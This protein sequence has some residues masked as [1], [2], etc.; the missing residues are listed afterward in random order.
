MGRLKPDVSVTQGQARLNIAL[1]NWLLARA[2]STVS[3]DD[4]RGISN[5]YIELTPGGSG[6][7]HMRRDYSQ[8]LALLLGISSMVLLITCANIANLLLARGAARRGESSVR[9]A[10]GASRGR[11]VRQS[12]TESLTLALIGGV[13]AL[14]VAASGTKLLLALLFRGP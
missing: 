8:T 3:A 10:L 13:L 2:G 9:L 4:Q 5:S 14:L 12:F 11:L 6:V 7:P 1:K